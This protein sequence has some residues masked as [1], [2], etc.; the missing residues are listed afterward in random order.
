MVLD[1]EVCAAGSRRGASSDEVIVA[2]SGVIHE[3]TDS[4]NDVAINGLVEDARLSL[5]PA[6][7]PLDLALKLLRLEFLVFILQLFL[8]GRA[9]CNHDHVSWWRA[10]GKI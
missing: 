4:G 6:N 5:L 1:I 2:D 3:R 7:L 8:G 10:G 9:R